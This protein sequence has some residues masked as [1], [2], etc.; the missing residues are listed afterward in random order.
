MFVAGLSPPSKQRSTSTASTSRQNTLGGS[1]TAR[2]SSAGASTNIAPESSTPFATP[3]KANSALPHS[4]PLISPPHVSEEPNPIDSGNEA[5]PSRSRGGSVDLAQAD[6]GEDEFDVLSRNLRNELAGRG[7]KGKS[8]LPPKQRRNFK[9]LLVDKVRPFKIGLG[10]VGKA[11]QYSISGFQ[12][13]K[14]ILL[15]QHHIKILKSLILPYPLTH[16]HLH[17]IQMV[18]LHQFGSGNMQN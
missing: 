2:R 1:T 10:P 6:Q 14:S 16:L 18:L 8:W 4:P 13:G 7:G 9:V 15:H 5:G 12:Q 3:K 17:H 11:D